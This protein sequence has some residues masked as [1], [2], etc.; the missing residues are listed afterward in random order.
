MKIKSIHKSKEEKA[1]E[2]AATLEEDRE[3]TAAEFLQSE[4]LEKIAKQTQLA[5]ETSLEIGPKTADNL[6]GVPSRRKIIQ[7]YI[8]M[9]NYEQ[10]I[11]KEKYDSFLITINFQNTDIRK[12]IET[13]AEITEENILVG[14]EIE[15]TV[16][17]DIKNE[18]W[19]SALEAILDM[20]E[21]DL[22]IEKYQA[23]FQ[24]GESVTP[25]SR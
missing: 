18:P 6:I 1:K 8:E 9:E 7:E 24:G 17:A 2:I 22:L 19:M 14:D 15:G 21:M 23:E 5:Q 20:K 4:N 25:S 12:V 3:I 13:F 16:T 11:N 10:L